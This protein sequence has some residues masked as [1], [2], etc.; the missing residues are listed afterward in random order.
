MN[1]SW[2]LGRLCGVNIYL[3]WSFLI[4]PTWV[5]LTS[6][7]AGAA[8]VP[9]VSAAFFVL[10]VFG[11]VVLHELGH[12]LAGRR[13]GIATRDIMLLPIGGLARL[14]EM[15]RHPQQEMTIAL[16]GP[17]VNFAIAGLLWLGLSIGG[18]GRV[19]LGNPAPGSFVLDEPPCDQPCPG[20]FQ[21]RARLPDGWRP[22]VAGAFGHADFVRS[23]HPRRRVHRAGTGRLPG[24]GRA[25]GKPEPAAGWPVCVR[26]G[27]QRS[28]GSSISIA[29]PGC[30]INRRLRRQPPRSF[31]CRPM[32][33]PMKWPEYCLPGSATFPVAQGGEVVGV[34]SRA[35]LLTAL[36]NAPRRSIDRGVND[37]NRSRDATDGVRGRED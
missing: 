19:D 3:H 15:P 11:C 12:A 31:C 23:R 7:A 1:Y 33:A 28:G 6:L 25:D 22:S 5:A 16:A 9:A 2:K 4:V 10:A 26:G 14:E 29:A 32:S 30:Q 20:D 36:V 24:D 21:P 37:R 17:A 8:L 27:S 18:A 35:A 13:Y 34:L